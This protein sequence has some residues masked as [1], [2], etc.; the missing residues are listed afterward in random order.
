MPRQPRLLNLAL[1]VALLAACHDSASLVSE[2]PIEGTMRAPANNSSPSDDSGEDPTADMP[3]VGMDGADM[4]AEDQE[5]GAPTS[6]TDDPAPAPVVL[7]DHTD[8]SIEREYGRADWIGS[9]V[10]FADMSNATSSVDLLPVRGRLMEE[11]KEDVHDPSVTP[12]S[13][14]S[15]DEFPDERVEIKLARSGARVTV[16]T[17]ETDD[18]GWLDAL[19]GISHLDLSPGRYDFEVWYDGH[20]AGLSQVTLLS[21]EHV[22]PVVRSDVDLTYLFTDFHSTSAMLELLSQDASERTTLDGME[23]VYQALRAGP[24]K[25]MGRPVTFLSGS[26]RGFK[27][28]LEHKIELDAM[29]QDGLILK[30]FKDIATANLI[31]F[32]VTSIIPELKEQIGYKL[33]W[34]M[35]MRRELPARTPELLMGDDSEADFVVYNLYARFLGGQ[36]STSQLEVALDEL[37]V[38]ESWRDGILEHARMLDPS[39]IAPPVG[40]YI[41]ETATPGDTFSISEWALP[42]LTR[43][44]AGAWPLMLDLLEEGHVNQ[45]EIARLRARLTALGVDIQLACQRASSAPF[46]EAATV[47]SA[48]QP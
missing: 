35:K 33:F 27:R 22:A 18:E 5:P 37:G 11:D 41:N 38:S 25:N 17:L 4:S 30:P 20:F 12:F 29:E 48:C 9:D 3:A 46:L 32:D 13:Q 45:L 28:T 43:H 2:T 10:V 36:L 15:Q 24:D 16:A 19:V 1:C 47:T 21:Q 14:L 40:I 42:G 39:R 6:P 31:D 26:P 8:P 34:L 7:P 44:H 23:V